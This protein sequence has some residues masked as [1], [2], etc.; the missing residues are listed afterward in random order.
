MAGG[1][2][3]SGIAIVGSGVAGLHLALLLQRQG[4]PVTLYSDKTAV[5][6]S[7]PPPGRA[8]TPARRLKRRSVNVRACDVDLAP[9]TAPVDLQAAQS[10]MQTGP[11]IRRIH[12]TRR[13]PREP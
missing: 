1:T 6:R 11:T 7:Q 2:P 12:G 5:A 13:S 4:I 9:G 10:A 3:S 8:A